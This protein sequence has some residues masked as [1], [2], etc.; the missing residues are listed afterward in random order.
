MKKENNSGNKKLTLK[1][2]WKDKRERAKLELMLYGIFFLVVIVFL[3]VG[4]MSSSTPESNSN[5]DTFISLIT[6]NYEYNINITINDIIYNYSGKVL[7]YNA[8]IIKNVSGNSDYFYKKNDI[9]YELDKD[10]GYILTNKEEV[11]NIINYNY[12]DINTIKEYIKLSTLDNGIYKVNVSDIILSSDNEEYITIKL[13]DINNI[14]LID[15]TNL[16]KINDNTI[17]NF[18]VEITYSNIDKIISL[19]E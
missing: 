19:E 9:Y 4:N 1:E 16:F 3:R 2:R 7:G 13:D 8:S 10:N 5:V 11:Y 17:D 14:V 12:L 15:Y 18:L 6:D